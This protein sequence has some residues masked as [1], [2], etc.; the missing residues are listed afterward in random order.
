MPPVGDVMPKSRPTST[1]TRGPRRPGRRWRWSTA[2]T[3]RSRWLERISGIGAAIR[4]RREGC[5]TCWCWR[6]QLNSGAW[7]GSTY[8]GCACDVPSS[9]Y[10]YSFAPNSG[11][12]RVFAGQREIHDYLRA[13]AQQHGL[14]EVLRCG[15]RVT[16]ARWDG[17]AGRWRLETTDGAYGAGVLVLATGPWHRP[18]RPNLPGLDE[19]TGPVFHT[20]RWDHSAD[21]AGASMAVV[22]SGASAVQLVPAIQA[23]AGAVHLFQ[24]TAQW[25]LP[26]P[27]LPLP[28]ALTWA[29]RDV[30]GTGRAMRTTPYWVQEWLGYALR[31]PG[32][33]PRYRPRPAPTCASR[34]VTRSY[35]GR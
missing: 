12:S 6:R 27:D 23:R 24:R 11:W 34:C 19:F 31:H 14:D 3:R 1:V 20:A 2:E 30:P 33:R 8:P 18:R 22:G 7:R 26:K 16:S 25:L 10:S 17:P 9:L 29:L 4:L 35:A 21:L 5:A 15:V 13:T 28:R 32:S